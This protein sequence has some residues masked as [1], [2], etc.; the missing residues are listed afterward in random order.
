MLLLSLMERLVDVFAF[1]WLWGG[2]SGI[3]VHGRGCALE[4]VCSIFGTDLDMSVELALAVL[5]RAHLHIYI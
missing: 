3:G 4:E 5:D 1:C 2:I